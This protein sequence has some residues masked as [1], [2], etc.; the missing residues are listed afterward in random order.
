[1]RCCSSVPAGGVAILNTITA[2]VTCLQTRQHLEQEING[3]FAG[4]M[5]GEQVDNRTAR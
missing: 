5:L 1:M 3:R 2:L 4:G